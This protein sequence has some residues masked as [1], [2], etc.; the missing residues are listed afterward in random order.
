MAKGSKKVSPYIG[1]GT[2][3]NPSSKKH[4]IPNKGQGV[5]NAGRGN[6]P[7]IKGILSKY[8]DMEVPMKLPSGKTEDVKV[9][10]TILVSLI[11]QARIGNIKAVELILDRVYGKLESNEGKDLNATVNIYIP[12]NGRDTKEVINLVKKKPKAKRVGK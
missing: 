8:L 6:T 12:D 9:I 3:S 5:P 10:D 11:Q 4:L 2:G 1:K 7:S